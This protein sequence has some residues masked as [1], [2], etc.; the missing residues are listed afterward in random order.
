MDEDIFKA[1]KDKN[2]ER[3]KELIENGV[4]INIQN[5]NGNLLHYACYFSRNLN[6]IIFLINNGININF[7]TMCDRRTP[8]HIVCYNNSDI[9]NLDNDL[10]IVKI[11]INNEADINSI[12]IYGDTPLHDACC[13]GLIEIVDELISLGADLYKKNN[14]GNTPLNIARNCGYSYIVEKYKNNKSMIKAAK[15]K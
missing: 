5:H 10:D 11:L 8:L 2:F 6:F 13:R 3:I 14:R 7:K 15:K 4:D 1:C 12:D 9:D